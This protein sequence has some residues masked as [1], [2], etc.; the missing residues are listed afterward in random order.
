MRPLEQ[1]ARVLLLALFALV[2]SPGEVSAEAAAPAFVVIVHPSNP[3]G[4]LE[5][6]FVADAFLKKTTRWP[7]GGVIKPVDLPPTS[8]TRERFSRDVLKR[9]V[10][11]VKTYW[12]QIIF[13]GRDV[14]PA[15]LSGD[16][17]V[18]QYV[19]THRGAIGYVS[20]GARVG[21]AK[22]VSVR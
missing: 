16:E 7:D 1:A 9:S 3:A 2:V 11:A 8:T 18:V 4:A 21:N 13:S 20:G 10:A 22:T 19:L 5:R 12:Q 15:E 6:S 17:A 14:P